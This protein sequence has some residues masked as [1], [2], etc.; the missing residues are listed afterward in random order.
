M[1]KS[2]V[3]RNAKD[4]QVNYITKL[5]TNW[6]VSYDNSRNLYENSYRYGMVFQTLN[7]IIGKDVLCVELL[8]EM[9]SDSVT[10]FSQAML[11]LY[12]NAVGTSRNILEHCIG[13]VFFSVHPIE[14]EWWNE[15][16]FKLEFLKHL[17]F[18]FKI[19]LFKELNKS[20]EIKGKLNKEYKVLSKFVHG[21]GSEHMQS[22]E[23]V[24]EFGYDR[25]LLHK[26]SSHYR[27]V[28]KLCTIML[29]V[30]HHKNWHKA[31]QL[32]RDIIM[33]IFS[34][35]DKEIISDVICD[36]HFFKKHL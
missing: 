16:E 32:K 21:Q 15:G 18:I 14:Y 33:D 20:M 7:S 27:N 6:K 5:E 3:R 10:S 28:C 34:D 1:I 2:E 35:T 4:F 9:Q 26:W 23:A 30:Y 31:T 12:K 22:F 19:R 8:R 11:G 17:D 13:H 24:Y 36:P 29:L 25:N